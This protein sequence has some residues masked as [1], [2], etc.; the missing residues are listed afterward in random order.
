MATLLLPQ[1]VIL[2]SISLS[3]TQLLYNTSTNIRMYLTC[4]QYM[5]HKSQDTHVMTTI[6]HTVYNT[7]DLK[8]IK[9]T[10]F[11]YQLIMIHQ[12]SPDLEVV[13]PSPP[14][15][16]SSVSLSPLPSMIHSPSMAV[17]DSQ[18]TSSKW[19]TF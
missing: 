6:N 8:Y 19:F 11:N 15:K 12:C 5:Y 9:I 17:D 10:S 4:S 3:L 14:S 13:L 16:T 2:I 18:I 1:R 7:P